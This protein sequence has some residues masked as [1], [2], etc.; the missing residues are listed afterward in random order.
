MH[1]LITEDAGFR[2]AVTEL[3][4]AKRSFEDLE[5]RVAEAQVEHEQAVAAALDR[6]EVY[7]PELVPV[8]TD[9]VTVHV[10]RR[11]TK[12]MYNFGVAM[13][14]VAPRVQPVL[15]ARER[16][17]LDLAM[18]T[19]PA[20]WD[21]MGIVVELEQLVDGDR[22]LGSPT[23]VHENFADTGAVDRVTLTPVDVHEA[24]AAGGSLMPSLPEALAQAGVRSLVRT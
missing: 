1:K 23:R 16:E 9:E 3:D 14:S 13:R 12:A 7:A 4:D 17:L 20:E 15:R 8:T 19:P 18:S 6:G 22:F 2:A 5:R 24:A 10:K 21:A 11:Y